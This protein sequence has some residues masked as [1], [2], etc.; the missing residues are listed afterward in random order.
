[1]QKTALLGRF[2]I[3]HITVLMPLAPMLMAFLIQLLN[4][5]SLH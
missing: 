1:M 2:L 4:I 5:A 3:H